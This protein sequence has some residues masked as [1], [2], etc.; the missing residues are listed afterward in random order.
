M[1]AGFTAARTSSHSMIPENEMILQDA[2]RKRTSIRRDQQKISMPGNCGE[3]R[4]TLSH[5]SLWVA[6]NATI[7]LAL[8]S[9]VVPI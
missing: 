1:A 3:S 8:R 9:P 6:N 4:E 7:T 5:L 2:T